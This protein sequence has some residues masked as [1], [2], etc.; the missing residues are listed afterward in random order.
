MRRSQRKAFGLIELLIVIAFIAV[1][2]AMLL[3]LVQRLRE[4]AARAQSVNNLRQILLGFQAFNDANR[5]LPFNGSDVAV[6]K[7][8]YSGKAIG[9]D[10]HSGSWAFQ[11]LPYIDQNPAYKKAARAVFAVYLCPGR[12][13]NGYETTHGGGGFTDYFYNNYLND[14]LNAEKPGG[15]DK[16]RTLAG[17]PDGLSNTIFVG[18]GNIKTSQYNSDANVT[19][20]VNI[21]TGGTT[22]T[23]RAGK[24]GAVSPAGATLARDSDEA[25]TIGSWGGPFA[26][27][28]L[29]GM[30]DGTVRTFPYGWNAFSDFLTPTGA[31]VVR[32]PA[33]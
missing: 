16:I 32:L 26:E 18:H 28:G 22:G 3:P 27:G 23:M 29:M 19:L 24:N 30:G 33:F 31:E 20:S 21:F 10:P 1:V 7:V 8:K 6:G 12:G 11:I 4:T 17:I 5:R 13:R 14:P 15:P 2:I 25:L 9:D